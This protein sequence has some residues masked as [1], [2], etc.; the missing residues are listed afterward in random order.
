ME[1]KKKPNVLVYDI[2]LLPLEA[3][4]FRLGK[5]VVSAGQLKN[6]EVHKLICI[7]YK[8]NKDKV[9]SLSLLDYNEK[10]MLEEFDKLVKISDIVI[11]K[12]NAAFDDK[13]INTYRMMHN[14]KPMPEFIGSTDDLQKQIKKYFRL[15]TSALDF[16]SNMFGYGGKSKMEMS[17][18]TDLSKAIERK[19]KEVIV[20]KVTKFVNYCN[21]DVSDTFR[22]WER[23]EKHFKPKF[24]HSVHQADHVCVNCGSAD[25]HANG[26][27]QAG[28][29]IY[30]QYFCKGHGGY[31]GRKALN[32]KT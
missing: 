6:P 8:Y 3:Y 9:K 24:N 5:Q 30:Q 16:V 22:A 7:S 26:K 17:D 2:E 32:A 4:V 10:Q 13:F 18:W 11:G 27:R 19:D 21:K 20:K 31:A 23:M 14:L 28:K 12:N 25:V 29:T 1:D 15:P